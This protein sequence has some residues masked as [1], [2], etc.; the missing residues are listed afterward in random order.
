MTAQE[1]P[2]DV[3]RRA[4]GLMRR[5]AA[6]AKSLTGDG[7]GKWFPWG[8]VRQTEWRAF[9][10]PRE[11][12]C[13]PYPFGGGGTELADGEHV[14]TGEAFV[15]HAWYAHDQEED[16]HEPRFFAGPMPEALAEHVASWHPLV[17]EAVAAWLEIEAAIAE[18]KLP[19]DSGA[20]HP[21]LRVA[22][23]YLGEEARDDS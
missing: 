22:R 14:P 13:A 17:A 20:V 11:V 9:P 7:N 23:A 15:E 5:R 10:G 16:W 21:A 12:P 4:A 2:A 6:Q 19:D 18:R 1:S 8:T 3:L